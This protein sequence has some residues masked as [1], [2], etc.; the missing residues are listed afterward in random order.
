VNKLDL[1][2]LTKITSFSSGYISG[3]S[4]YWVMYDFPENPTILLVNSSGSNG[5]WEYESWEYI[6]KPSEK[7]LAQFINEDFAEIEK[8]KLILSLERKSIYLLGIDKP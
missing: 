7:I 8:C 5:G 2:K 6:D 3:G 4:D 1:S